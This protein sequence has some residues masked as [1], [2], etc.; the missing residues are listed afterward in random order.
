ME[1]R[2]V[3]GE[4]PECQLLREQWQALLQPGTTVA[5]LQTFY[6]RYKYLIMSRSLASYRQIGTLLASANRQNLP[7]VSGRLFE[8]M[9]YALALPA[10]RGGNVNALLH[11]SGYLKE[12]LPQ[13]EKRLLHDCIWQYGQGEVDLEVPLML[14]RACF[15]RFPNAYIEQQLFLKTT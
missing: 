4:S 14:L 11:I 1:D 7:E 10:T 9:L 8:L 3:S 15:Q 2:G 6:A 13:Q 12:Q 5:T